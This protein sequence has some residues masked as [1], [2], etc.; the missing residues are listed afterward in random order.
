M[1]TM[2]TEPYCCNEA[3][4]DKFGRTISPERAQS[5]QA[6]KIFPQGKKPPR[7]LPFCKYSRHLQ[8]CFLS[9]MISLSSFKHNKASFNF[10]LL[11]LQNYVQSSLSPTQRSNNKPVEILKP[12]VEVCPCLVKGHLLLADKIFQVDVVRRLM[13]DDCVGMIEH[14]KVDEDND[15][16]EIEFDC[17]MPPGKTQ[18]CYPLALG[19]RRDCRI[20]CSGVIHLLR[21]RV[22]N[23][24]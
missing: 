11:N 1:Q 23:S 4:L 10:L 2:T 20:R 14:K 8:Q 3:T 18:W 21:L 22:R 19:K 17:D 5:L 7:S 6:L 24:G 15:I 16:K 13:N 12:F 9:Q